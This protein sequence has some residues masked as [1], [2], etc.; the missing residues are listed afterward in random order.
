MRCKG[1]QLL[2]THVEVQN[3]S[4]SLKSDE[5]SVIFV[6]SSYCC[7]VAALEVAVE[8]WDKEIPVHGIKL[9]VIQ[10]DSNINHSMNFYKRNCVA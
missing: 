3:V 8:I 5:A 10:F 6:Y 1:L 9:F 7:V 2:S 4:K